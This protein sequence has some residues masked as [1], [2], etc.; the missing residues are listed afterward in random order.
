[1]SRLFV[2]GNMKLEDFSMNYIY[3]LVLVQSRACPADSCTLYLM[4]ISFMYSRLV[5]VPQV[6]LLDISLHLNQK[7]STTPIYSPP[8]LSLQASRLTSS[9][10]IK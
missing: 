5:H 7:H 4:Q 2:M 6:Y 9:R 10:L 8:Y 3:N 1:M